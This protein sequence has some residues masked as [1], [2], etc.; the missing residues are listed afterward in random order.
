MATDRPDE[1]GTTELRKKLADVLNDAVYGKITFVTTRD[2][3]IAAIVPAVDAERL[4][5][6]RNRQPSASA[7]PSPKRT[8]DAP[9]SSE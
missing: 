3:R 9:N 4:V 7:I 1:I 5:A 6:E 8:H 2:R